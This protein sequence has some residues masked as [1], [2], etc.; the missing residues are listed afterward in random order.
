MGHCLIH[1]CRGHH[2]LDGHW[3]R[4]RD[5]AS[6]LVCGVSDD[7]ACENAVDGPRRLRSKLIEGFALIEYA[8]GIFLSI[9]IRRIAGRLFI[10]F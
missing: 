5:S 7:C 2:G 3:R 4:L 8:L 1:H 6:G 10:Q 9:D